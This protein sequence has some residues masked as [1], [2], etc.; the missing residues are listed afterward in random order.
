MI[1]ININ[2]LIFK[3]LLNKIYIIFKYQDIFKMIEKL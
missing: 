3:T 1:K 2:V